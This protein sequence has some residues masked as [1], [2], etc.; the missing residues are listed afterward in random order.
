M[1]R[2]LV[3]SIAM[4]GVLWAQYGGQYPNGGQYPGSGPYPNGGQYPGGGIGIPGIPGIHLPKKK[5]KDE[6]SSKAMVQSVDGLLRKLEEKDLLLQAE[7]GKILSFRLIASTEF[8]GKDGKQVRDSL[9]HPGDHLT[10]DVNPGDPETAVHVILT[11]AGGGKEREAASEP[12]MESRIMTPE[13]A[14]FGKPHASKG[15]E[16]VADAENVSSSESRS[17]ESKSEE[18]RQSNDD[19]PTLHRQIESESTPNTSTD[20]II[21]DARDAAASYSA[22][23][24][25]FL[26]QQ[27][28]TRY[29]GSRSGNNWRLMDTVTADVASVNGK[30]DYRNIKVNGRPT[31]RPEDSGSWSTGEFQV[32]LEDILSSRTNATFTA[33]GEDHIAGRPAYVFDLSVDQ[34]HSHWTLVGESGRRIKPAY[35]GKIWVDKETRRVLR[36]EQVAVS[37][38]RDFDFDKQEA[39]LEYGF[40]N[41]D[42]RNYLLPTQSYD[43]ACGTGSN[44]CSRNKIEFRNYRK[45]STDANITFGN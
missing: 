36:I 34:P 45:F 7:G 30:E 23:L 41:I 13:T 38:P 8:R 33:R 35:T 26:V 42:G 9:L 19:K 44:N 16:K 37:I 40:V 17:S 15:D 12:V 6:S 20:S 22:D 4:T 28:T 39:T 24:P 1:R 25:N 3:L 11:K 14:D 31:D 21:D 29:Q 43:V 32:T 18:S 10:I 5:A 2:V 27:V